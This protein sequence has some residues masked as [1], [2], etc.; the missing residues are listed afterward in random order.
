MWQLFGMTKIHFLGMCHQDIKHKKT[1]FSAEK[2]YIHLRG[3][4]IVYGLANMATFCS[5]FSHP[6]GTGGCVCGSYSE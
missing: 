3:F 5:Q 4:N 6:L 1:F 2:E